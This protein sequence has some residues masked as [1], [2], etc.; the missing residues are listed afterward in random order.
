[1]NLGEEEDTTIIVEGPLVAQNGTIH[2]DRDR[3]MLNGYPA[4]VVKYNPLY[5]TSLAE[6]VPFGLSSV[7][8]S[9]VIGE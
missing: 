8:I 4:Q 5:L 9:W 1:M 2:F 6:S 3:G 7:D